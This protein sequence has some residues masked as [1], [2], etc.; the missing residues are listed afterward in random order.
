[1][2][3]FILALLEQQWNIYLLDKAVKIQIFRCCKHNS[4]RIRYIT[5]E[6]SHGLSVG[7]KIK[8]VDF[9]GTSATKL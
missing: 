9:G 2:Q 3:E 5:T 6:T 7:N 4:C 8:L 1:M